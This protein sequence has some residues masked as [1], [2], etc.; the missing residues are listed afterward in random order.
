[1]KVD[2]PVLERS[3]WLASRLADA[4]H[5]GLDRFGDRP[6]AP[7]K[8]RGDHDR[9]FGQFGMAIGVASSATGSVT[10]SPERSTTSQSTGCP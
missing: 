3:G 9:A 4:V 6:G 8:P 2:P 5:F 10:S 1:L 7:A